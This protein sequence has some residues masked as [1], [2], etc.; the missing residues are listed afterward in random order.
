[1]KAK[2]QIKILSI[3][4]IKYV[5]K[6]YVLLFTLQTRCDYFNFNYSFAVW[7]ILLNVLSYCFVYDITFFKALK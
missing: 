2:P 3:Y 1:M 4:L 7:L 6:E 5:V